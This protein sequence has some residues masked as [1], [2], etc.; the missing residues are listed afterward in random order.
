MPVSEDLIR[1]VVCPKCKG[2]LAYHEEEQHFTC[3]ACKL[4]YMIE[5]DIPNF[6]ID[7]AIKLEKDD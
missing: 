5:D 7:E 1:I 3:N 4:R 2:P 6:L